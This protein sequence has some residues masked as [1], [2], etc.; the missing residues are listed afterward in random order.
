MLNTHHLG[1]KKKS[2]HSL[3]HSGKTQSYVYGHSQ[4]HQFLFFILGILYVSSS[5][6]YVSCQYLPDNSS[7]NLSNLDKPFSHIFPVHSCCS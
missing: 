7:D 2:F 4:D 3:K 1:E 5:I 6:R